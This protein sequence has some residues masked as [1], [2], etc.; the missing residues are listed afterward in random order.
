[1]FQWFKLIKSSSGSEGDSFDW[2]YMHGS[3]EEQCIF[4]EI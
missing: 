2:V 4:L 3:V 1:M